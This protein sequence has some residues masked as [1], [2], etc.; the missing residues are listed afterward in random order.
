[1]PGVPRDPQKEV[2][3]LTLGWERLCPQV[4]RLEAGQDY[5]H[6]CHHHHHQQELLNTY[7]GL[8]LV[9]T[10][11]RVVNHCALHLHDPHKR[12]ITS[13]ELLCIA[14][15]ATATATIITIITTTR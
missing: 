11:V 12:I 3:P 7:N 8:L 10:I 2:P 13:F 14:T 1:M 5:H 15:I 9:A 6:F 4:Q